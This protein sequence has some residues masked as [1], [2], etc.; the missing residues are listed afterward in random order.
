MTE[1]DIKIKNILETGNFGIYE[2]EIKEILE[3]CD[4][5]TR[6]KKLKVLA[7]REIKRLEK[8]GK[9]WG[10]SEKINFTNWFEF[11]VVV[12]DRSKLIDMSKFYILVFNS[13]GA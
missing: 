8:Q 2:N 11:N 6:K 3:T 10:I 9:V 12:I 13:I 1:N 5:G 4:F 7:R